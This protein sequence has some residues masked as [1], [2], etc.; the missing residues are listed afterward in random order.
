[1]GEHEGS[2][3]DRHATPRPTS[4]PTP[5][6]VV[7]SVSV[8]VPCYNDGA[9]IGGL[10]E[11]V[12][13][14]LDELAMD[15]E[16]IVVND[17]SSDASASV[18]AAARV[19]ESR[20]RVVTHDHNRGYG[21]ALQS[22]FSAAT[23]D[24]VFYTD[25][26]GQYDPSELAMLVDQV[27]NGVD[28]VQGYKLSRHDNVARR[29]IGRAYHHV[30]SR[31]FG[32]RV[33]DTD[34]DFR[35]IRRSALERIE[36]TETS[37]VICVEL[38]RRLESSGACF[39]EVGVHHYPRTNGRSTFFKPANVA[40]TLRDLVLLWIRLVARRASAPV[41]VP[42]TTSPP[43]TVAE[44]STSSW[45]E[46][47]APFFVSRAVSGSLLVAMGMLRVHATMLSGFGS[48]DGRWYRAIAL[49]GYTA[50]AHAHHH[51]TPWPFFPFFPIVMRTMASIGMSV[52]VAG[53]VAN[54]I[55]F[56]I[57][58]VGIQRLAL[59]H[60]SRSGALL[61]VWLTALGPLSFVFSMLYPSA[62]FL[63]ASVWAFVWIEQEHDR[64]AGIAAAVAA[65]SRP[66]GVVVL[67]ALLVAVGFTA[68]RVMRIAA[69]VVAAVTGWVL[70]NA[71]R[72][73]DPLRFFNAKTAWHEITMLN[74]IDR[75]TPNALLHITL[76]G[77]ALALLL[78]GRQR[79]PR[80]WSW[81]TVL[82]L[83]PSLALGVVGLARYATETFPPYIAGGSLL[84]RRDTTTIRLLFA[85]LI[86]AQACCAFYFIADGRLI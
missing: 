19:T 41:L 29:L 18:L 61:A 84:E 59:R 11:R 30:V 42:I 21:G 52:T 79:I 51:Q 8:F 20:L 76:A 25:G 86:V 13:E 6:P 69:P 63:A 5:T 49:H 56:L 75:P 24:W 14:T 74:F 16:I 44:P 22:G 80:S 72:T 54:H 62:V 66:N 36:L 15:G 43:H 34:C 48:W 45:R 64:A 81:F 70:F 57:A 31:L 28:V 3:R 65:L 7:A 73:G 27:H 38:V 83:L 85:A 12:A 33:R 68:R 46:V 39:V 47:L 55:A 40:R 53:I 9:T 58:L 1:M 71:M 60:T 23:R 2:T 32:L 4:L 50:V 82:Y 26:D 10:V 35:L 67:I 17:G 77:V 78:I 37:G